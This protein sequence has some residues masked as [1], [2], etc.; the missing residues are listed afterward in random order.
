MKKDW[1]IKKL[2]EV[3]EFLDSRRKPITANKRIKGQIPYYGATGILDYVADFLF[4]EELILLGEDGAKWGPGDKSAFYIS[5]KTWVNNHAHVLKTS[6]NNYDWIIY[7]LNYSDLTKFV[8]GATVPKLNQEKARNIPIP[9]PPLEEQKRMVKILDEKFAHLET[10][11]ANAQTNLQNAK[12]LFQ[13]QLTKAFSNTT[14]KKKKMGDIFEMVRGPFGGALKKECF[15][16]SGYPVYEQQCAIHSNYNFRY[17]IDSTKYKEMI[18]FSVGPGDFV[19][20]CSGVTMAKVSRVPEGTEQGIINQALLK[21]TPRE[22]INADYMLYYLSASFFRDILMKDS[23]GAAIPNMPAVKIL[24]EIEFNLPPLPEQKR[25]VEELD[26]LSQK[27]RQLQEIY[28][29]QI[30]NCDEL[31]QSLLQKAFEGEL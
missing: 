8:K 22:N 6:N 3:C 17:F 13:S 18:R 5:G 21:L 30:A 16:P 20:S 24:K 31:K 28:T 23:K 9:V 10:I 15:K 12:D 14:W 26:T 4:D 2:G 7:Y 1:E 29:K 11:K 19:M 27:V 25:I